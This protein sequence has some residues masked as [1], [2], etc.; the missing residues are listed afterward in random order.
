MTRKLLTLTLGLSGTALAAVL[1]LPA[2][3]QESL[4]PEGFGNPSETPA[5]RPSPTPAPTAAPSQPPSSTSLSSGAAA[6]PTPGATVGDASD[7]AAEEGEEGEETAGGLKYD[8]PP[9]ARR[10]LTRIGPLTPE[11]VRAKI[12]PRVAE[13]SK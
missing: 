4:L 8:L 9:G 12:R 6:P 10:L 5:P 2:L 11:V 3:A 1:V 13:L 7:E